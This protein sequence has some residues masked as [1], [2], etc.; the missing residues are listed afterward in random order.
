MRPLTN[1]IPKCLLPYGD[2]TILEYQIALLREHGIDDITIVSGFAA[3]R[4]EDVAGPGIRFIR[5]HEYLTTNSIYSLYLAREY[6]DAALVLLNSDVVLGGSLLRKLLA[7]EHPNALLVDFDKQRMD[8]EMNVQ[9]RNGCLHRIGK[10]IPAR[11]ADGE[12]AQICKFGESG[13]RTL[14]DE[15]TRLISANHVDKFPV[16]AY[17]ALIVSEQIRVVSVEGMRW[18]EFDLPEEYNQACRMPA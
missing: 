17:R 8:G 18:H 13:A 9:V 14:R 15:I 1:E 10:D 2:G 4:V 12:S 11:E 6:M 7:E 5:N 16:Y 3:Q